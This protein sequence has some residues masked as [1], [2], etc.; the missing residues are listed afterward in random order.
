MQSKYLLALFASSIAPFPL[1]CGGDG[2]PNSGIAGN[3]GAA[4]AA[5]QGGT[6]GAAGSSSGPGGS[7]GSSATGGTAPGDARL[8]VPED[9]PTAELNAEGGLTLVALTLAPGERGPQLF[10]AVRNDGETPACEAGMT[11]SFKDEDDQV[12]ATGAGTLVS[13][14]YYRLDGGTGAVVSCVAPSQIAMT[15]MP[16]LPATVVIDALGSLEYAFPAFDVPGIV[17]LPG[18]GVSDVQAVM[19]ASGYAFTGTVTNDV[20]E[21]LSGVKATLFALNGVGR[22]LGAGSSSAM[23]DLAPGDTWSFQTSGLTRIGVGHAAF[24]TATYPF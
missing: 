22:P 18:L 8:F 15:A 10:A 17:E 6:G 24:V 11:V 7:A 5:A 21:T 1:A 20:S 3:A 9:L 4:G 12:I 2:A 23:S 13:G 19:T 16:E 14:R